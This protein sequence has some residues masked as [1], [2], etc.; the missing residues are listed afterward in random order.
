MQTIKLP[1][2]T[3]DYSLIDDYQHQYSNCLHFMYNRVK[4]GVKETEI[5][6]LNINNIELLDSWFKQSC[7][8]E[9]IQLNSTNK[10]KRLIFGG[11]YNFIQR[12]RNKISKEQFLENKLS[13]L[14]SIGEGSNPSVK[15]NRKFHLEPDLKTISFK[16]K[17]GISIKLILPNLRPNLLKILKKLYSLQENAEI[18]ISY[19]INK[20]HIYISFNELDIA[21]KIIT[22]PI[23]NRIFSLDL[24]PNFIGWSVVDWSSEN[25]FNVIYKGVYS[26]KKINDIEIN[27]KNL[28]LSSEHPQRIYLN[29]KRKYETL[30]VSNSLI[31]NALHYKCEIF[32]IEELNIESNNK[33]KGKKYNK[34]VN[35]NWLRNLLTNNLNKHCNLHHIKFVKVKCNYSSFVGNILFRNLNFPDMILSSIEISRRAYEFNAQYIE[36]IKIKKKN[37]IFPDE[38]LFKNLLEKSLEEFNLKIEGRSLK[39]LYYYFKNS[40]IKYRVPLENFFRVFSLKYRKSLIDCYVFA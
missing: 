30:Q 20:E 32:G 5:K 37:I 9:A 1:Y 38:S 34:L 25:E 26:I 22:T 31:N 16:P 40:K 39:N 36:K 29:N 7:V 27:L 28:K 11:K 24:N 33:E 15:G 2:K 21:N 17:R 10:N 3:E 35:N 4:D 6:H 8:K 12:C 18:S 14:Y 19:K 13:N 23:K